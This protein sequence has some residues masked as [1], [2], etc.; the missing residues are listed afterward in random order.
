MKWLQAAMAFALIM[1]VFATIVTIVLEAVY[2]ILLTREQGF[3]QMMARLFDVVLQPRV[4]S[5]LRGITVEQAREQFLDAVTHNP[6]YADRH[7]WLRGR[8]QPQQLASMTMMQLADRLADTEVGKAI[9][10]RGSQYVD[11]AINDLAQKFERFGDAASQRF[12]DQARCWCVLVSI[13]IALIVNLDAVRVFQALLHDDALRSGVIARYGSLVEDNAPR[14]ADLVQSLRAMAELQDQGAISAEDLQTFRQNVASAQLQLAEL[15]D[16]G[17]PITIESWPFC[18]GVLGNTG[19]GA[20]VQSPAGAQPS[21]AD[22][23][24]TEV[25][26]AFVSLAG[27]QQVATRVLSSAGVIWLISVLLA[28]ALIGLGAP[29]WFD[30]ARGMTRGAQLLRAPGPGAKAELPTT[31]EPGAAPPPRTPVE[32]FRVAIAAAATTLSPPAT[33][34]FDAKITLELATQQPSSHTDST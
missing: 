33:D 7:G 12:Q 29:F 4:A 21:P 15:H 9:A 27:V 1:L 31:L 3:R 26:Q 24:C 8:I 30:L 32:A 19:R 22:R 13:L 6:A 25:T 28:G 18:T 11:N 2:R 20:R 23:K 10:Q 16:T 5:L 14:P 17:L 34:L